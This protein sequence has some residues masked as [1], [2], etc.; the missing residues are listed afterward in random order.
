MCDT[1]RSLFINS[2]MVIIFRGRQLILRY[3]IQPCSADKKMQCQPLSSVP[4]NSRTIPHL[5]HSDI[6]FSQNL[7]ILIHHTTPHLISTKNHLLPAHRQTP[8]L[9]SQNPLPPPH[10]ISPHPN[11][12]SPSSSDPP[13]KRPPQPASYTLTQKPRPRPLPQIHNSRDPTPRTPTTS[14]PPTTAKS[15]PSP[16][17]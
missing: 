6:I 16:V 15:A 5:Q 1:R 10:P 3:F 17:S 12:T 14:A 11:P 8:L 2:T 13:P 9:S 4:Y 7:T